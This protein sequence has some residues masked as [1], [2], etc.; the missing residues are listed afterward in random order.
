MSQLCAKGIQLCVRDA[1][2]EQKS[3]TID[4]H[5]TQSKRNVLSHCV[6]IIKLRFQPDACVFVSNVEGVLDG[7][8]QVVG[9]R[10][11]SFESNF[12]VSVKEFVW[13]ATTINLG[14]SGD[15]GVSYSYLYTEV[16]INKWR[17]G[18]E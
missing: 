10:G 9:R 11:F 14:G 16:A 17:G 1:E 6:T 13:D 18:V 3:N 2:I 4:L 8:K 7:N 5:F 15:F 12:L